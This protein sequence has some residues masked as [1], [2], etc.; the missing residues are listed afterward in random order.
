MSAGVL[1]RAS[2]LLD[3]ARARSSG[4]AERPSFAIVVPEG[5]DGRD[6]GQ[7]AELSVALDLA[8]RLATDHRPRVVSDSPALRA[9]GAESSQALASCAFALAVI[10]RELA[11]EVAR[12]LPTRLVGTDPL[13]HDPR[14]RRIAFFDVRNLLSGFRRVDASIPYRGARGR[15]CALVVD[16]FVTGALARRLADGLR[17]ESATVRL[18]GT[19]TSP[20]V[21]DG[22]AEVYT[23]PESIDADSVVVVTNPLL[24]EVHPSKHETLLVDHDGGL[25][26]R[27]ERAVPVSEHLLYLGAQWNPIRLRDR[28]VA[29]D[30]APREHRPDAVRDP[31]I[32]VVVPVYDRVA[33]IL[34]LGDSLLSQSYRNLEL[35]FVS[36]GSPDATLEALRLVRAKAAARRIA[37]R[38][39]DFPEAFGCATV[40]RDVGSYAASGEF[41]LY[42]DSDD[43]VSPGFF[44]FVASKPLRRDTIYYPRRVFR[45][46]GRKLAVDTPSDVIVSYGYP[47][48]ESELLTVLEERGNFLNNSGTMISREWFERAGGIPHDFRYC[49]DYYLWL[50]LARMGACAEEHAGVVNIVFH[51]GNNELVVGDP[52]WI[53][54]AKARAAEPR[55]L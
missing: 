48:L 45:N 37:C 11:L 5:V 12:T 53:G 23:G 10:D 17:R 24:A 8:E 3:A 15:E 4:R 47:R 9:I 13:V 31:L 19:S 2:S 32:S 49:E 50:R 51:R 46:R 14:K 38:Q 18:L 54:R 28:L 30:S 35:V 39:I 34:R 16:S 27:E 6:D 40:P 22:S 20:A 52:R 33:D 26:V 21:R 42:I 1:D 7:N 43:Y 55:T 25:H 41:V 29:A 44:D 36:N